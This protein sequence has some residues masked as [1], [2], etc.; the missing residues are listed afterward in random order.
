MVRKAQPRRPTGKRPRNLAPVL[1]AVRST[2][3]FGKPTHEAGLRVGKQQP[4]VA[5]ASLRDMAR[6]APSQPAILALSDRRSLVRQPLRSGI[7]HLR[8]RARH[9][10]EFAFGILRQSIHLHLV[11]AMID[12]LPRSSTVRGARYVLAMYE[13]S[14]FR[15]S[16]SKGRHRRQLANLFPR[17]S[18]RSAQQVAPALCSP[19]VFGIQKEQ[20]LETTRRRARIP[21]LSIPVLP[22]VASMQNHPTL[23][24][25]GLHRSNRP[26]HLGGSQID[27]NFSV[28]ATFR[29]VWPGQLKTAKASKTNNGDLYMKSSLGPHPTQATQKIAFSETKCSPGILPLAY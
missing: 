26:S 17:L 25:V 14:H 27:L 9:A 18:I 19:T 24:G 3:E 12:V 22:A 4:I 8:R 11:V 10:V 16:E 6:D 13:K 20:F 28:G 5:A 1:A 23:S 2:P 15:G 7:A 21:Q 29:A